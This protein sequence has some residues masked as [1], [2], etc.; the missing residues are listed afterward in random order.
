[1]GILWM[2]WGLIRA[3]FATAAFIGFIVQRW[4]TIAGAMSPV[5]TSGSMSGVWTSPKSQKH[6]FESSLFHLYDDKRDIVVLA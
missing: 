1:M 6:P 3:L 5:C 4:P 2:L